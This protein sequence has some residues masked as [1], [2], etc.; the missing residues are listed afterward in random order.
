M[1]ADS[2][3]PLLAL[4]P[5]AAYFGACLA[6]RAWRKAMGRTPASDAEMQARGHSLL[7]GA[8][9]RQ[10]GASSLQPLASWLI[11]S[12]VRPNTLTMLSFATAL[13]AGTAIGFGALTLG[14]VLGLLSCSLDYF[15]GR[16]ARLSARV[17]RAGGFLD[18]TLD[19]YGE[20]AFL[21]GAAVL[22]RDSLWSFCACLLAMASGSVVSYAR[23]KAESLGVELR[24]GLMQRP[25]RV[26][27]FCFGACVSTALD[28]LLPMTVQQRHAIFAT[29]IGAL[30][31]S[32]TQ[33]AL[34]RIIGGFIALERDDQ[35]HNR[36]RDN[37]RS[38]LR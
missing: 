23:A 32:T 38:N 20:A 4:L 26:L 37:K 22:L 11:R 7:L 8:A 36:A 2:A 28:G 25:E 30:A 27:L 5:Y 35:S 10:A 13:A 15:D 33:T 18:S 19:R 6:L 1:A 14:G 21:G 34:Q 29:T 24:S 3:W 12:R 31:L 17:S 16:I 9:V